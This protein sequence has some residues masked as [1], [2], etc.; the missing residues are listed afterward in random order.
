MPLLSRI[1]TEA[2]EFVRRVFPGAS[3]VNSTTSG[4]GTGGIGGR[5]DAWTLRDQMLA[6]TVYLPTGRGSLGHVLRS[7]GKPCDEAN[8][9]IVDRIRAARQIVKFYD[10]ALAGQWGADLKPVLPGTTDAVDYRLGDALSRVWRWSN[11][12][13]RKSE[14]AE[15]AAN[16]GSVGLRVV[17]QPGPSPRVYLAYDDPRWMKRLDLDERDNV[18]LVRLEYDEQTY[19]ADGN[20]GR[21]L[22]VVEVIAKDRRS[23][24][25]DGVETIPADQRE[26]GLGVCPYVWLS[27]EMGLCPSKSGPHPLL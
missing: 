15:V 14:I 16:Q 10:L 24:L 12:N 4:D 21:L 22:P 6:G 13:A 26:N 1:S 27:H 17:Y 8:N 11:L 3:G 9:P 7:L 19:D 5:L 25:V 2:S 18:T 20:P 23:K